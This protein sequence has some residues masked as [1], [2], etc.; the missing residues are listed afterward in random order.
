MIFPERRGIEMATV[1]DLLVPTAAARSLS[2]AL[3]PRLAELEGKTLGI[4]SNQKINA[5]E[6]LDALAA[7]LQHRHKIRNVIKRTKR[8]QSQPVPPEV[9]DDLVSQCDA[10]IHGV[11]D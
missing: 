4:L 6:V 9:L 5:D 3:A 8:I 2:L 10:V 1:Y 11:G 7:E